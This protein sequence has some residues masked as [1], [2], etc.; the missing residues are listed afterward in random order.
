MGTHLWLEPRALC[1]LAST[2]S[3]SHTPNS[4]WGILGSGS[5]LSHTLTSN[6]GILGIFLKLSCPLTCPRTHTHIPIQSKTKLKAQTATSR[7]FLV[8]NYIHVS[9]SSPEWGQQ[10]IGTCQR[11]HHQLKGKDHAG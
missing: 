10:W 5:A 9:R 4:H 11:L 6:W 3:L 8:L 2:L 7:I 1:M